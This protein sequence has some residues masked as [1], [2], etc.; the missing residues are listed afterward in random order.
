MNWDEVAQLR[1]AGHEIGAHSRSHELLPH[2]DAQAQNDEVLGSRA[3]IEEAL[4]AAPRSFCYPNG[5]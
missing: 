3:A 2:L 5:S 4:G 1:Q